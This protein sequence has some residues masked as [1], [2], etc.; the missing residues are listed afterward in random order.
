MNNERIKTALAQATDTKAVLIGSGV[1]KAVPDT[2]TTCFGNQTAYTILDL[3][4]E[5]GCF[6][7][8]VADLFA[9]GDFWTTE[10]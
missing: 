10:N 8:C 4:F 1:I 7:S 5:T 6:A 9:P 2:F 3:A